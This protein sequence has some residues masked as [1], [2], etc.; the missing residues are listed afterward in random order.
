MGYLLRSERSCLLS[1]ALSPARLRMRSTASLNLSSSSLAGACAGIAAMGGN[2]TGGWG[3]EASI[4][5][6]DGEH[7]AAMVLQVL[8]QSVVQSFSSLWR[9]ASVAN[10]CLCSNVSGLLRSAPASR[11]AP[12]G[13]SAHTLTHSPA[14]FFIVDFGRLCCR[15]NRRAVKLKGRNHHHVGP[16]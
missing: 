5:T 6:L 16:P 11:L 2:G 12:L 3:I 10:M 7:V 13:E 8:Q 9:A 1:R 15:D 4:P 14:S